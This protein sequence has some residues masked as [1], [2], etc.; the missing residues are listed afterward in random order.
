MKK[1]GS[2][3]GLKGESQISFAVNMMKSVDADGDRKLTMSEFNVH[4]GGDANWEGKE[5]L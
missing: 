5:D 3:V 4:N 1:W 2:H